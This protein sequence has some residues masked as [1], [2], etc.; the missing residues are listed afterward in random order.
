MVPTSG[1]SRTG[2]A[3]RAP[4]NAR[5]GKSYRKN[6]NASGTPITAESATLLILIQMLAHRASSSARVWK[7]AR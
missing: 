5:P 7:K 6:R 3:A 4:K 1:G 2:S